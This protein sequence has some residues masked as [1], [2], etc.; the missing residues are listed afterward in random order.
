MSEL[1]SFSAKILVKRTCSVVARPVRYAACNREMYFF[2]LQHQ[3]FMRVMLIIFLNDAGRMM[4][5][6]FT[7]SLF[8]G[9][10]ARGV[11]IN[12]QTS[13]G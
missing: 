13:S 8:F 5:L 11:R 4:G 10:S 6:T 7:F 1:M 12:S 9:D 3:R 2:I